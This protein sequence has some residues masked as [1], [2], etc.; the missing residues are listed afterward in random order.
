MSKPMVKI[1]RRKKI[2]FNNTKDCEC[3]GCGMVLKQ[4][5]VLSSPN[6]RYRCLECAIKYHL[7]PY[8]PTVIS[9]VLE[10]NIEVNNNGR[11]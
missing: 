6:G 7:I 9:K 3:L 2:Y 5:Y 8:I 11:L 1:S 4:K 10:D